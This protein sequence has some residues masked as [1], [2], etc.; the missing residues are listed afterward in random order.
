MSKE[1]IEDYEQLVVRCWE[2]P[3]FK[4]QLINS[5]ADGLKSL[6]VVIPEGLTVNVY[7]NTPTELHLIIPAN[8]ADLSDEELENISGGITPAGIFA[9][10]A[11][12]KLIATG[13]IALISVLSTASAVLEM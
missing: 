2:D 11:G 1:L 3:G 4:E 10:M 9:G 5:P 13:G 7:E 6:G 8:D 12:A